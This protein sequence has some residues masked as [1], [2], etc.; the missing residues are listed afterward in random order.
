MKN[1]KFLWYSTGVLVILIFASL[2]LD[3]LAASSGIGFGLGSHN[4]SYALFTELACIPIFIHTLAKLGRKRIGIIF[5]FIMIFILM[6][7]SAYPIG[8]LLWNFLSLPT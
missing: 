1:I 3:Y 7:E 6:I 4:V 8:N 5:G 2:Y